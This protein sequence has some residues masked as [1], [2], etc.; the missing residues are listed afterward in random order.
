MLLFL[1]WPDL[2][3]KLKLWS[4]ISTSLTR[5]S[6]FRGMWGTFSTSRRTPGTGFGREGRRNRRTRRYPAGSEDGC[7]SRSRE[8]RPLA[9]PR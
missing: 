3:R 8:N 6:R 5:I 1:I 9:E 4:R 2:A 7:G